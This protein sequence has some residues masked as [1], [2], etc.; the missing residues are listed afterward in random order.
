MKFQ[1]WGN[2]YKQSHEENQPKAIIRLPVGNPVTDF[3]Q[4]RQE[5]RQRNQAAQQKRTGSTTVVYSIREIIESQE[6]V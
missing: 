3:D 2:Y 1:V 5:A 4:A 6:A